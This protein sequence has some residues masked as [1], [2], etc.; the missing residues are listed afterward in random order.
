M[1]P[2][3]RYVSGLL[4]NDSK[5]W[6]KLPFVFAASK[7]DSYQNCAK[8]ISGDSTRKSVLIQVWLFIFCATR[9]M[10]TNTQQQ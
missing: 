6:Y 7:N 9:R 1:N 3:T 8:N 4:T 5:R 2:T 10:T